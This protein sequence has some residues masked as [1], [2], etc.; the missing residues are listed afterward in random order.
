[1]TL[2]QLDSR[3]GGRSARRS[4]R[5]SRREEMLP[6]LRHG[7]PYTEPLDPEQIT[8]IH[9][10]SVG[11]LED[12]GVDF[13]DPVA[14]EDARLTLEWDLADD[15]MP[16]VSRLVDKLVSSPTEADLESL[17]ELSVSE[18]EILTNLSLVDRETGFQSWADIIVEPYEDIFQ[19]QLRIATGSSR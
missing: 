17:L 2:V 1:M 6:T 5:T 8:R 16:A 10:A 14:L 9:E 12:V 19:L 7:L 13:R 15:L 3:R 18:D 4:L 11:I